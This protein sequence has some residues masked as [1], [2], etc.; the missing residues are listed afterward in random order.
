MFRLTMVTHWEL[1]ELDAILKMQVITLV[2]LIRMIMAMMDAMNITDDKSNL[3]HVMAWY[4]RATSPPRSI[5]PY[6][7][8]GPLLRYMYMPTGLDDRGQHFFR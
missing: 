7:I 4:R 2:L 6:G 5:S 3:V 1:W 8:T